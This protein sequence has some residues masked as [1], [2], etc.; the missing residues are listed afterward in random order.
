MGPIQAHCIYH[1]LY[2]SS[3][4]AADLTGG[5]SPEPRGWGTPGK[6]SLINCCSQLNYACLFLTDAVMSRASSLTLEGLPLPGWLIP[7]DSKMTYLHAHIPGA[8]QPTQSPHPHHCLHGAPTFW[9]LSSAL[10]TPGPGT[11]RVGTPL[12]LWGIRGVIIQMSKS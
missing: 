11:R 4:A 1:A 6:A 9:P 7:G 2:F 10:S 5:T 12:M 3:N 8:N